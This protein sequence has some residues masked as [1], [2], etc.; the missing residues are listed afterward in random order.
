M[1]EGNTDFTCDMVIALY[2]ENLDWLKLYDKDEYPFRNIFLYNKFEGNN[3]KTSQDLKCSIRGKECV[4][5]NLKNEGRCDHTFLYH[6]I[7]HWD[8]LADVT[9][10]TKGSSDLWREKA[11]LGFVTKKVFQTKNTVFSVDRLPIPISMRYKDF[12]LDTY[13]AS[14]PVNRGDLLM[15]LYD[16][17][18]ALSNP[19]PFGKWYAKHF[20]GLNIF[21]VSY[22]AVMGISRDHIK[23]HP[24]IYYENLIKELEGHANPEVGHYFERAW[25]AVFDPIPENCMYPGGGFIQHAGRRIRYT[26]RN[27]RRKTRRNT[28]RLGL[29]RRY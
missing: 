28:R 17:K 20:P 21:H 11:K 4:K 15:N 25:I 5:I 13:M 7:H 3:T 23:Q 26:R 18:M 16:R 22:A 10:F 9:I 6:I 27:R 24:K 12:S 19:R 29:K 8:T 1:N 14:H 2:K